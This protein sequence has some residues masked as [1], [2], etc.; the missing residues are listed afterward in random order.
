MS[1][2]VRT[3][4]E[5]PPAM[6]SRL[7]ALAEEYGHPLRAM[8]VQVDLPREAS[9]Q[10]LADLGQEFGLRIFNDNGVLQ[11]RAPKEYRCTGGQVEV[12]L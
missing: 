11:Y 10:R 9:I 6:V 4:F 7:A 3:T 12:Q 5:I 1:V 2:L 8:R